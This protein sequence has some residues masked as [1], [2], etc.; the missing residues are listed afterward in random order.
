MSDNRY[1][2]DLKKFIIKLVAVTFAIIVVINVT[3]NL[4][5]AD[6]LEN[7][8]KLLLF[9][10]ID[11]S[12][13]LLVDFQSSFVNSSSLSNLN[14]CCFDE[15]NLNFVIVGKFDLIKLFLI[16]FSLS[17]LKICFEAESFPDI[18][19]RFTFEP[20]EDKFKATLA[21]PP[22]LISSLFGFKTGTGASGETLSTVPYKY[23][24]N[25]T[26]PMT[27]MLDLRNNFKFIY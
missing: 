21:A 15:I 5:F 4:I 1:Q 27:R 26:S 16:L 12:N 22:N 23:L 6:K 18:P 14:N 3:Y 13:F 25:M 10:A 7:I 8:N 2:T 17:K 19:T 11:S 9:K 20:N 24:S